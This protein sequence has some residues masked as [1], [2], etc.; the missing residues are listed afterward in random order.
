[1]DK[2]P[3]IIIDMDKVMFQTKLFIS[4]VSSL[5]EEKFSVDPQLFNSQI[6][7]FYKNGTGNLR[8]YGFFNHIENLG[9][10]PDEVE[11]TIIDCF[12]DRNYAYP[13]V[14]QFLEF[15]DAMK[16]INDITLLTYG[17]TR[18]QKLKYNCAPSLHKLNYVDTLQPKTEYLNSHY[19]NSPGII[20]DDKIIDNLP[21]NFKQI[22]LTRPDSYPDGKGL[23]TL[24]EVMKRWYSFTEG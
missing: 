24:V 4:D 9:L 17:E 12:K 13:D 16:G 2:K 7:N 8:H 11:A 6:P 22:W 15:L 21:P 23:K 10:Q 14:P 5:I 3:T 19:P 20:I 1:M 18:F